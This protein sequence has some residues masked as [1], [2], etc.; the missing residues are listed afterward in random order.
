M[1]L[2]KKNRNRKKLSIY[3]LSKVKVRKNRVPK[4]T[5]TCLRNFIKQ[6]YT[7]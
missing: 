6:I 3:Y 5:K 4:P 7:Q 2:K 1:C